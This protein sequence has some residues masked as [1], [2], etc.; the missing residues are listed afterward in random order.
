MDA[1]DLIDTLEHHLLRH[2]RVRNALIMV[3]NMI[4]E[5]EGL[6]PR[7]SPASPPASPEGTEGER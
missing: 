2:E 1:R 4:R 5:D 3:I 7:T 6:P